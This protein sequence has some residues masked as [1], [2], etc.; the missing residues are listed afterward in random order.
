M[1][2]IASI[3]H[4]SGLMCCLRQFYDASFWRELRA[5]NANKAVRWSPPMLAL[6]W[7]A[8]A[9]SEQHTLGDRFEAVRQWLAAVFH[10]RRR[11]GKSYQ[12]F[13]D[14]SRIHAATLLRPL[15]T[16]LREV[17]I[18]R[19][20]LNDRKRP[21][22]AIDGSKIRVPHTCENV[23]A[24]GRTQVKGRTESGPQLLIVAAVELE[25]RIMWDWEIAGG[26]ASEPGLAAQIIERLPPGALIIKDAGMVGH[27]WLKK[28][29]DGG[30]HI[31]MRVG[32]NFHLWARQSGAV[33]KEGGEVWLWP[34]NNRVEAP[35]RLR[36]IKRSVISKK[37]RKGR[38]HKKF[39]YLLTNLSRGELCDREAGKLYYKRW[40]ASEIGFR[41]LKQTLDRNTLL[42]RT[43]DMALL[44]CKFALL[45]MQLLG[46]LQTHAGT[47][48]DGQASLAQTWR[49]WRQAMLYRITGKSLNYA[50]G[51]CMLDRYRRRKPKSRRRA[52]QQKHD[53]GLNPPRLR[54]ITE[55]IKQRW[56]NSFPNQIAGVI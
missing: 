1:K 8:F 27:A 47:R 9:L 54:R 16:K 7:I 45:G 50:L 49:V 10:K 34:D 48:E 28:V 4:R 29:L 51:A 25:S 26:K 21:V 19:V 15:S 56:R 52:P 18:S 22:F 11:P 24:F 30:R 23:A 41:G 3:K 31:L 46:V 32:G 38:K 39:I 13:I 36:L 42:S 35:L 53:Y 44:E 33:L 40:A 37:R 12:G 20:G 6:S 55:A 17:A 5:H 14:A 2:S 43:P